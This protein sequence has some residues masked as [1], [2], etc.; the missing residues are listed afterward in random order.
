[1][2]YLDAQNLLCDVVN[3]GSP[4]LRLNE[5][6]RELFWLGLDHRIVT[7]AELVLREENSFA[8]EL[9]KFVIPDD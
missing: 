2:F 9:S 4:R 1:M 7:M 3:R 8:D 5:L 6:A